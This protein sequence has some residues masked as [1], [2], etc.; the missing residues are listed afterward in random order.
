MKKTVLLLFLLTALG[1]KSQVIKPFSF[2][3][4]ITAN[5]TTLK[6]KPS[7]GNITPEAGFGFGAFARLKILVLYAELDASYSTHKISSSQSISGS[8]FDYTY[9]LN[10]LDFSG[11]L[12]WRVVGIGPLGNFRLF[13]GYNY[14]NYSSIKVESNGSKV[15]DPSINSG[16][17]GLIIGTGVDLWRVVFNLKYVIGL[18]NLSSVANNELKASSACFSLGFRF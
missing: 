12:G 17:G 9:A 14:C 3:P 2:G 4:I 15:K 11:I 8:N 6:A 7:I 5:A 1:I 13:T 16:N 10:G 18:S